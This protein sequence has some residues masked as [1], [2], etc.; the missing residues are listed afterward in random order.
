MKDVD[1]NMETLHNIQNS[2]DN[3]NYVDA[4]EYYPD[5]V[6]STKIAIELMTNLWGIFYRYVLHYSN[7]LWSR[8]LCVAIESSRCPL[9]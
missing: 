4:Q 8:G 9:D 3:L 5:A 7:A 2:L 1:R 6:C